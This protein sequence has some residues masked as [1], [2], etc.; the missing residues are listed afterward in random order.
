MGDQSHHT[1]LW[2]TIEIISYISWTIMIFHSIYLNL[3]MVKY[4][5]EMF[6]IKRSIFAYYGLNA[7]IIFL[8]IATAFAQFN[9]YYSNQNH[10]QT[11]NTHYHLTT[12]SYISILFAFW[13][14][15]FFL[16]TKN[17]MIF[18]KNNWTFHA[19]QSQWKHIINPNVSKNES[20]WYISKNHKYGNISFMYKLFGSICS[21]AFI[22]CLLASNINR[23]VLRSIKSDIRKYIVICIICVLASIGAIVYG[24]ILKKTPYLKD[25][26]YIHWESKINSRLFLL[27]VI[28]QAGSFILLNIIDDVHV[29]LIT[30]PVT[31]LILY[32]MNYIS[33]KVVV[34]KNLMIK[35]IKS[36]STMA[37]KDILENE[38]Y[39]HCFM[40]HLSKELSGF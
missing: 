39:F 13:F 33:T 35:K 19:C 37:L 18:F 1:L 29:V 24:C 11:D 27:F 20:N 2:V 26:F 23:Y 38:H 12:A 28:S 25:T 15:L 3:N 22:I 21:T 40:V 8:M 6:M 16:L 30:M 32:V 17:W 14:I 34:K 5:K 10:Q 31:G 36:T 7:G 4:N 9:R